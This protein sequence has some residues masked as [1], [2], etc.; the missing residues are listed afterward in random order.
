MPVFAAEWGD[1][2][3]TVSFAAVLSNAHPV[4][5]PEAM[6][7]RTGGRSTPPWSVPMPDEPRPAARD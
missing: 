5:R 4:Q 6:C 2:Q 3:L 1:V 7:L